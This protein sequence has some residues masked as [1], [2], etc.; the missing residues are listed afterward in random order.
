MKLG[1][2]KVQLA[3]WIFHDY[4]HVGGVRQS[5]RVD[6]PKLRTVVRASVASWVYVLVV[7]GDW[8][9]TG[10]RTH[11]MEVKHITGLCVHE[12][13]HSPS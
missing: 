2:V 3:E 5:D 4:G 9:S 8:C 6:C 1:V 11:F 10:T 13:A 12:N 7:I